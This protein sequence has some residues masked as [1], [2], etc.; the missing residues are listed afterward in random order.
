VFLRHSSSSQDLGNSAC[1]LQSNRRLKKSTKYFPLVKINTISNIFYIALSVKTKK[2]PK[3][4]MLIGIL[5]AQKSYWN[6]YFTGAFTGPD[7][8]LIFLM[9]NRYLFIIFSH[10]SLT[11][12]LSSQ[13]D[14]NTP[15]AP[16]VFVLPCHAGF[17]LN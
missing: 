13:L 4:Q 6:Y 2:L 14:S 7:L 1:I 3:L 10:L 12:Y 9:G 8:I 15:I 5:I 17:Q 16:A 11:F